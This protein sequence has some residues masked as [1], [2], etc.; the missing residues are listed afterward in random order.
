MR[1]IPLLSSNSLQNLK[2][3]E[4]KT[5]EILHFHFFIVSQDCVCDV[6]FMYEAKFFKMAMSFLFEFLTLECDISR[7]ILGIEVS[8]GS[9]FFIFALFHLSL[10]YFV[11]GVAF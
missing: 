5:P 2:Q 4:Q 11:S 10:T 3:I 8:E 6:I 7:T 1:Q 9:C